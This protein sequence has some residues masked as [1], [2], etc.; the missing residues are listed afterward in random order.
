MSCSCVDRF[1]RLLFSGKY[2]NSP[3]ILESKNY[4]FEYGYPEFNIENLS[5]K[6]DYRLTTHFVNAAF[7]LGK[8]YV[9]K[10]FV[11]NMYFKFPFPNI[12]SSCTS[13]NIV[14]G[15]LYKHAIKLDYQKILEDCCVRNALGTMRYII[16][17]C[18]FIPNPN[19]K[20]KNGVNLLHIAEPNID[21][22]KYLVEECNFN[23]NIQTTGLYGYETTLL[24]S[25]KNYK[26]SK[27]KIIAFLDLGANVYIKDEYGK[28]VLDYVSKKDSNFILEYIS[29]PIKEPSV[30]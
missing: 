2:D 4:C 12:F 17:K 20:T 30:E 23:I 9:I 16:E 22:I 25:V 13:I 18:G 21:I 15:F 14:L 1:A 28:S 3:T 8:F 6:K 5:Y 29:E 10:Y 26:I 19:H 27:E 11:E 24:S 7:E